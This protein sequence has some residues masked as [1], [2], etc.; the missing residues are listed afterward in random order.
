MPA[1]N[2]FPPFALRI[3]STGLAQSSGIGTST[4]S[5]L[6]SPSGARGTPVRVV[7]CSING[8]AASQISVANTLVPAG[9]LPIPLPPANTNPFPSTLMSPF[10]FILAS[11]S[12]ILQICPGEL[13][14]RTV[15]RLTVIVPS[16]ATT[17]FEIGITPI[18]PLNLTKVSWCRLSSA[19]TGKAKNPP[20]RMATIDRNKLFFM[21]TPPFLF[22]TSLTQTAAFCY[23]LTDRVIGADST[24]C[25]ASGVNPHTGEFSLTRLGLCKGQ[26]AWNRESRGDLLCHKDQEILV[27]QEGVLFR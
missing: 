1:A 13:T 24:R 3:R 12:L 15:F 14:P 21:M 17:T 8:A 22:F 25:G 18:P 6:K 7:L 2:Q 26:E 27:G 20:I 5:I 23:L 10:V 16:A 9:G 11:R 19:F 4:S